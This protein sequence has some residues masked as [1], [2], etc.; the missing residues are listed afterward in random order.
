MN[1]DIIAEDRDENAVLVVE[2]KTTASSREDLHAFLGRLIQMSIP[3]G[4]FVDLEHIILLG[5]DL[6]D[7]GTPLA[8]LSTLDVLGF[9]DPSFVG[10]ASTSGSKRIYAEYVMTL[11]EAWLRDLAYHWKSERPP[12]I[13]ELSKTGLVER[14]EG[15]MTRRDA[16][17]VVSPL[18]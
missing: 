11:V 14:L 5:R 8:T 3:F 17:I 2:V 6:S 12:G 15:G 10:K 7:P 16:T 18:H 13:D 4:M 1:V 9:Y